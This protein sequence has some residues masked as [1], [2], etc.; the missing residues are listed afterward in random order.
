MARRTGT[1][2]AFTLTFSLEPPSDPGSRRLNLSTQLTKRICLCSI[3]SNP[4]HHPVYLLAVKLCVRERTC[5]TAHSAHFASSSVNNWLPSGGT[6]H[7]TSFS[8]A[9]VQFLPAALKSF[10]CP[11]L[12]PLHALYLSPRNAIPHH[13]SK[14]RRESRSFTS[15]HSQATSTLVPSTLD[16]AYV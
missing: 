13:F 11:P 8:R 3:L 14:L 1:P 9:A 12:C 5:V 15:P 6:P 10:G 16:G 2:A 7:R 4:V